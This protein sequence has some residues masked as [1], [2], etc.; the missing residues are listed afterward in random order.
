MK[1]VIATVI[2]IFLGVSI[3]FKSYAMFC[4]DPNSSSLQ[5][6]K[7]PYPWLISPFSETNPQADASTQFIKANILV[8]GIGRGVSCTYQNSLGQYSI[9]IASVTK[10]PFGYADYWIATLGGYGCFDSI[11]NCGFT[12]AI[13]H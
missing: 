4:P 12:T 9:W 11:M 2:A 10:I 3:V 13:A 6:G 5:W 1:T 8:A 7:P